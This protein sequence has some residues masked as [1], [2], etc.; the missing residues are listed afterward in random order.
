MNTKCKVGDLALIIRYELGC[1]ANIGRLVN[2]IKFNGTRL[3]KGQIWEIYPVDGASMMFIERDRITLV[4][5]D[6]KD[7]EHP[8]AWL[9]PIRPEAEFEEARTEM[10]L[11]VATEEEFA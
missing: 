3:D 10:D 9:M 7:I 11:I 8:D 4:C 2:I 5:G 1:E 6:A